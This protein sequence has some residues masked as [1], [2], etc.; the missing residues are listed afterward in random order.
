M[1]LSF[2]E[3]LTVALVSAIA[4]SLVGGAGTYYIAIRNGRQNNL[5]DLRDRLRNGIPDVYTDLAFDGRSADE[6][7]SAIQL[8]SA[9]ERARALRHQARQ[10]THWDRRDSERLFRSVGQLDQAIRTQTDDRREK[11]AQATISAVRLDLN[12]AARFRGTSYRAYWF[13]ARRWRVARE[14]K[15]R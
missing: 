3:Q 10:G 1:D 11:L 6:R 12:L 4:G 8:D 9:L 2:G 14:I 5:R 15:S 13:V 7:L